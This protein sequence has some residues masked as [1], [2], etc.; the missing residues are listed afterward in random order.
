MSAISRRRSFTPQGEGLEAII[1]PGGG[2]HSVI[3]APIIAGN[4]IANNTAVNQTNVAQSGI[5]NTA[6][7][8]GSVVVAVRH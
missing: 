3:V 6:L 5:F 7:V 1:T 2:F 8:G 4:G